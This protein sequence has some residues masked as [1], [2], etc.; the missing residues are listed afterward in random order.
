MQG[1]ATVSP[2]LGHYQKTLGLLRALAFVSL[3]IPLVMLLVGG[4]V[5]WQTKQ[6]EAWDK[7][8]RLVD[9]LYES[10]SKLFETQ[11]L[12]IEQIGLMLDGLDPAAI[13][14]NES[15]FHDRLR[16]ML[17]YLPQTR[18][19]FVVQQN[20]HAILS[21]SSYLAH[22]EF[23]MSNR[24]YFDYFQRG[25][26][27][28]FVSKVR[29]RPWD[30]LTVFS[31]TIQ[32]AAPDGRFA[33][34]IGASITPAYFENLFQTALGAYDD[35]SGRIVSLRRVDGELLARSPA[36][37]PVNEGF[38]KILAANIIKSHEAAGRFS[39]RSGS[40]GD[41]RDVV[42]RRFPK[43][44]II[45]ASSISRRA[46]AASWV[47]AL[48]P[49]LAF[50]I[51]ATLGLFLITLL[52]LRRTVQAAAAA[53][54]AE[55]ERQ[56]RQRAEE[57][58]RQGQKM[59]ALGKLTGGVAHDF[60]NL[61]AV[62]L[63]SAKL[64]K[65]RPPERAGPLLDAIMQAAQR[66]AALTRQLLSFSRSQVLLPKILDPYVEIPRMMTLLKPSLRGTIDIEVRVAS[67][68]W[69][70]ELDPSEWD[71]AMLNIAV[72]ARDAMPDGGRFIIAVDNQTI[73]PGQIATAPDLHGAFVR[74]QLS[75]TGRSIA[76]DVAARAFEPFFT[77]K[78]IGSGTGLGLSQ[79]YGF[80]R[81]AGGCVT[82]EA[83]MVGGT[84][85]TLSCRAARSRSCHRRREASRREMAPPGGSCWSR[86]TRAWPL[87]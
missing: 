74:M 2:G 42:W 10:T 21:G 19:L 81:Q 12:A 13:T 65:A 3:A 46:I 47:G 59:E 44:D 70:V 14:A 84:I 24:D 51:P 87:P 22:S 23:D 80:A 16:A 83:G 73:V 82:I 86:M 78:A 38:G 61:L 45:I 7:T 40:G 36:A 30:D 79:V 32:W 50:G 53:Q 67:D 55:A 5:S 33:G 41:Y 25:G 11:S 66:G 77:T 52:A 76:P 31:L 48:L 20:G 28:L 39:Y 8:T 9:L 62:I 60:N 18:N 54:Q 63:G 35:F 68:V 85:V 71:I 37:A 26:T 57:A 72:N 27:G 56:R 29:N 75:D 58:V 43:A 49:H 4:V 15:Q 69:L 64:A 34:V 17:H 6:R 1:E